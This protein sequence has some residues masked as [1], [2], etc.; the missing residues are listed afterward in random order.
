MIMGDIWH[1]SLLPFCD[2][3]MVVQNELDADEPRQPAETIEGLK[4]KYAVITSVDRDDL[5]MAVLCIFVE[6]LNE[7]R[8]A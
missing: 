5:K 4:L 7:S 1:A 6:V 3:G 2:V 8:A